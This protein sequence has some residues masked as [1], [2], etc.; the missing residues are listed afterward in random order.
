MTLFK[1]STTNKDSVRAVKKTVQDIR[2]FDPPCAHHPYHPD[3]RRVLD[4]ANSGRVRGRVAAPVTEKTEYPWSVFHELAPV[5][6]LVMPV[7]S[8][9]LMY[10]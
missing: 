8:L 7:L 9:V 5:L 2:R 1:V 6:I 10:N 3:I 4:T